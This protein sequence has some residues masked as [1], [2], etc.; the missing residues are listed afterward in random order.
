MEDLQVLEELAEEGYEEE[1]PMER[2]RGRK[3][4][5]DVQ[6]LDRQLQLAVKK[7]VVL[8]AEREQLR[9]DNQRMDFQLKM[10]TCEVEALMEQARVEEAKHSA[11]IHIH[12]KER[13]D[14]LEELDSLRAELTSKTRQVKQVETERAEL[15][16]RML[17][18]CML[19]QRLQ[20][21]ERLSTGS[22]SE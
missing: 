15:K 9:T 5:D 12:S 14:F 1:D 4:G 17:G 10:R 6:R 18:I 13:Q 16:R 3:L 8:N 2:L 7:I 21:V 20:T 19:Q 11:K 22:P